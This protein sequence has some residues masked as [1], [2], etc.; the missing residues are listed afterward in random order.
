MAYI[1]AAA[2][3]A[4]FFHR[5]GDVRAPDDILTAFVALATSRIMR[6]ESSRRP[7]DF[8]NLGAKAP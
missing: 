3:S 1:L 4:R 5:H 2:R 7:S 6:A 8:R